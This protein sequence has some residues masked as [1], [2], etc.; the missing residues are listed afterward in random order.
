MGLS[1]D[2]YKNP[3]GFI[4]DISIDF[5]T[6]NDL[7]SHENNPHVGSWNGTNIKFAQGWTFVVHYWEFLPPAHDLPT[8]F[9]SPNAISNSHFPMMIRG[10]TGRS[11]ST[12]T[13]SFGIT[14]QVPQMSSSAAGATPSMWSSASCQRLI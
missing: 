7:W 13:S 6:W 2:I 1:L 8:S 4:N 9:P 11:H 3:G 5:E 12:P 14:P 10:R